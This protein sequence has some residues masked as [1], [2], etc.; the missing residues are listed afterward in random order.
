[1]DRDKRWERIQAAYNAIILGK[2]IAIED[3]SSYVKESYSR[4]VTDE[5]LEP[6]VIGAPSSCA[7][8]DSYIFFNFRE[9]RMRE[10]VTAI[11]SVDFTE[12]ER[13]KLLPIRDNVLCFTQYDHKLGLPFLFEQLDISNHL[14]AVVA[15]SGIRQLRVAE[16]EKYPHVTY[17]LNGGIEEPYRGED[18]KMVPSPRDVKTYD[19]RPEMSARGVTDLVLAGLRS[20]DYGLIVV[21]FANCDMVGHTGVL[22]AGIK[23]VETVDSCLG[24]ILEALKESGGDALIIADHGNAE[25]MIDYADGL[26]NTAHTTFPVPVVLF[27]YRSGLAQLRGDGALCDVA[28]TVL[29]MM[30]LKKPAE[31]TGKS[32]ILP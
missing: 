28:P 16:T 15:Q 30:G 11:C 26:P 1:M 32:L 12:F 4:G 31:M 7:E 9:D 29:E 19:Q 2:G 20:K 23:A 6:A 10:I 21:N 25:Q 8:F 18:R 24:E 17:F 3:A 27:N 14:G 5:F 22:E 13:A